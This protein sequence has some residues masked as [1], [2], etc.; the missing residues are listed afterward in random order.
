MFLTNT[1]IWLSICMSAVLHMLKIGEQ[2]ISFG[3]FFIIKNC[4]RYGVVW[5]QESHGQNQNALT[6]WLY[7]LS[8]SRTRD[9][10]HW[11]ILSCPAKTFIVQCVYSLYT[12]TSYFISIQFLIL[13]CTQVFT[14][15]PVSLQRLWGLRVMSCFG[16]PILNLERRGNPSGRGYVVGVFLLSPSSSFPL[17]SLSLY[18]F[19]FPLHPSAQVPLFLSPLFIFP[20]HSFH[21][22]S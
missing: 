3:T 14:C 13:V 18:F 9:V 19:P 15:V 5:L 8:N 20:L 17:T 10:F 22:L 2:L 6:W 16:K 1:S 11:G 4:K 21:I 12:H 7:I